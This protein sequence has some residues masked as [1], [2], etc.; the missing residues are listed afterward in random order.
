MECIEEV[1]FPPSTPLCPILMSFPVFHRENMHCHF[2]YLKGDKCLGGGVVAVRGDG[3]ALP[4]P[5][6]T[7][8][9]PHPPLVADVN[10]LLFLINRLLCWD[11][12]ITLTSLCLSLSV[13][14]SFSEVNTGTSFGELRYCLSF[15]LVSLLFPHAAINHCLSSLCLWLHLFVI[16]GN[17]Y[18][19]AYR[20]PPCMENAFCLQ[21]KTVN[22]QRCIVQ[23]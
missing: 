6:I 13:V 21:M 23:E 11:L 22:H 3:S 10:Q 4:W 12:G 1:F 14:D 16:S 17:R 2:L 19:R 7:P 5:P 20:A 9:S 15:T 18:D 8:S